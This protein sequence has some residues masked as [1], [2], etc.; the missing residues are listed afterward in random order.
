M[1]R[2]EV[3]GIQGWVGLPAILSARRALLQGQSAAV[4]PLLV[5]G[6]G[7][8]EKYLEAWSQIDDSAHIFMDCEDTLGGNQTAPDRLQQ[9]LD[10]AVK[11]LGLTRFTGVDG[12]LCS[13]AFSL[14]GYSADTRMTHR[15][16]E[17]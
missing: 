15:F 16:M 7:A 5:I 17:V 1:A 11:E 2:N 12:R 8:L 6:P 3:L 13:D 4:P 10:S 14:M 9:A